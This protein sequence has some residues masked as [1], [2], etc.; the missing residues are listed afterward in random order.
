MKKMKYFIPI[1]L[2]LVITAVKL[3][4]EAYVEGEKKPETE[5]PT[6]NIS[7]EDLQI[8]NN[9][10]IIGYGDFFSLSCIIKHDY[11]LDSNRQIECDVYWESTT[12]TGAFN[13][14]YKWFVEMYYNSQKG[15]YETLDYRFGRKFTNADYEAKY[16]LK[17]IEITLSGY[18]NFYYYP[19]D[20]WVV[21]NDK[22]SRGIHTPN[23]KIVKD[24][25]Y[26]KTG[27]K[28]QICKYCD[29]SLKKDII[30]KKKVAKTTKL[31]FKEKSITIKRGKTKTLKYIRTPKKAND[32][33][34]WKSSK[35]KIVK[36]TS[37]GKIK[38]LKKGTSTIT[39]K[40][41]SGKKASI[42]IKVK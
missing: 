15:R 13:K 35:P 6:M 39:V 41:A 24:S 20:V 25:T 30:P 22:C 9:H 8:P 14:P 4:V 31:K 21:F 2:L 36:V 33:I 38:A 26:T 17:Y 28:E 11:L 18:K 10:K 40:A 3:P 23:W 27:I 1:L 42:K 19:K 37:N 12:T 5:L 16:V 32:K 29:T 7:I 34:T